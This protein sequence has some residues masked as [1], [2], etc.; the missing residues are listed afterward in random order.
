MSVFRY[1]K[2]SKSYSFVTV[3]FDDDD[4][5]SSNIWRD[6]YEHRVVSYSRDLYI[7]SHVEND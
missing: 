3:G 7:D 4:S 2:K 5:S 1:I 6:S